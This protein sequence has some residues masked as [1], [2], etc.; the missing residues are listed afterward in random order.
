ME[1]DQSGAR[2]TEEKSIGKRIK[3][4]GI[5]GISQMSYKPCSVEI[6]KSL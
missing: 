1:Q 5:R 3:T 2:K 6:P 4:A